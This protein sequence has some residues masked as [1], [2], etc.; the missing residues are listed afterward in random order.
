MVVDAFNKLLP[1]RALI[2]GDFMLDRY[3]KGNVN[4]ISPEAPVVILKAEEEIFLPGG[5]GNVVLNL[6][7]LGAEVSAMGRVGKDIEGDK[8]LSLLSN[9]GVDLDGFVREKGYLTPVKSRFIANSQQ[10]LRVDEEKITPLSLE[11]ELIA[12]L[13]SL[14]KGKQVVAISDYGKGFLSNKLLATII[15]EARKSSIPVIVD[16]KGS[17]FSKYKGAFIIKPNLHEAY[18]AAKLDNKATLEEVAE[19]LLREIDFEFLL[20]TRSEEGITFFDRKLRRSDFPV[21]SREIKDVT[22]A[23]DTVLAMICFAIANGLTISE[24]TELANIAAGIV[25]EHVGCARVALSDI[26]IRLLEHNGKVVK[27]E[28]FLAIKN[29]LQNDQFFILEVDSSLK[30]DSSLFKT[31]LDLSDKRLIIY[32]KPGA[33]KSEYVAVLSSL[34]TIDFIVLYRTGLKN[35]IFG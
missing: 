5:A 24:A 9:E 22:G 7:S 2:I 25:V 27:E 32:L 1:I 20:I 33:Y 6:V 35:Q 16:P 26:A 13:P 4:R 17:D 28:D 3:V 11:S 30:I 34:K 12:K 18:S 29:S 14:V 23:G 21:K 19:I 8:L 31:I 10:V 15:K